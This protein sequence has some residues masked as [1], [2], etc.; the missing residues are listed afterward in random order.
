LDKGDIVAQ[1]TL[2]LGAN[3]RM[4]AVRIHGLS[5]SANKSWF[6]W[7]FQVSK[8]S[9]LRR[10][11][12][13]DMERRPA[14]ILSMLRDSLLYFG[15]LLGQDPRACH[16]GRESGCLVELS[17][18]RGRRWLRLPGPA[19][20]Q[21]RQRDSNSGS[22]QGIAKILTVNWYHHCLHLWDL[23]RAPLQPDDV[24]AGGLDWPRRLAG[25]KLVR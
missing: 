8:Y 18:G 13:A 5:A 2:D 16:F 9:V 12:A 17:R 7:R 19:A 24:D 25:F 22:D 4:G 21:P 6:I 15:R 23:F 1:Q 10:L 11:A 14:G 20:Q 3:Q